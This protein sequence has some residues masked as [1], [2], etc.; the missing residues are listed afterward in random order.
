MPRVDVKIVPFDQ[1]DQKDTLSGRGSWARRAA[2]L[3]PGLLGASA[4]T[5][6]MATPLELHPLLG[7]G[8]GLQGQAQSTLTFHFPKNRQTPPSSWPGAGDLGQLRELGVVFSVCLAP[9]LSY[10]LYLSFAAPRG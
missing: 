3:A 2:L 5:M 9:A 10:R 1:A 6:V 4:R 8:H 7:V